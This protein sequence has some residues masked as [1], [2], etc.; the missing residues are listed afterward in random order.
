ME[1]NTFSIIIDSGS[2]FSSFAG[3][4]IVKMYLPS[5]RFLIFK[6]AFKARTFFHIRAYDK[7]TSKLLILFLKHKYGKQFYGKI[8]NQVSLFARSV[9]YKEVLDIFS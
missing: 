5:A 7:I 4:V 6:I 2:R 1:A 9:L 8:L 3:L